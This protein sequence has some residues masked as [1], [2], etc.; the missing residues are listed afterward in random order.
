MRRLPLHNIV[1]F[2]IELFRSAVPHKATN[3]EVLIVD[4]ISETISMGRVRWEVAIL[5]VTQKEPQK[6]GKVYL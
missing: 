4:P 2:H 6:Q 3:G 1:N 5:A